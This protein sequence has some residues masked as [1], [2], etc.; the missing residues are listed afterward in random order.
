MV[1]LS[2]LAA[3]LPRQLSGGQQQRVA[4]ARALVTRPDVL[5][6]DEPLSN[7]DAKL[8]GRACGDPSVA[9][10]A[11]HHYGDGH[12]RSGRSADHG[13]PDGCDVGRFGAAGRHTARAIRTPRRPLRR[14]FRRPQQPSFGRFVEPGTFQ[15]EGGLTITCTGGAPGPA[16]I[17][18]RPERVV[19][20]SDAT[21]FRQSSAGNGRVRLL[22]GRLDRRARA[23]LRPPSASWSHSRTASTASYRKRESGLKSAGSRQRQSCCPEKSSTSKRIE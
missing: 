15:T 21:Q 6:L 12:S 17:A 5:L 16:V 2:G 11:G 8:R 10:A 22:S 20:G 3:R 23:S 18:V 4:L 19:L 14:W 9:A 7:L 13:R 1:R